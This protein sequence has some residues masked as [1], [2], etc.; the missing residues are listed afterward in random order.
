[1]PKPRPILDSSLL[2]PP[3]SPEQYAYFENAAEHPFQADAAEPSLVNAWWLAE[4][5]L[6]AY[7]HE[8][9]A[10]QIYRLGGLRIAGT[11]SGTHFGGC[12]YVLV[13]EKKII[14][15]F[16][17]TRVV[18]A[19]HLKDAET[20]RKQVRKVLRD[21]STDAK[22]RQVPWAGRSGGMV[23]RGFADSF[24][25]LL[26][27]IQNLVALLR[28][29]NPQLHLWLTGHSLGAALA[30]LAAECLDDVQGIHL[31]GSPQVGDSEFALKFVLRGWRFRHHA[32][33]I[34]WAPSGMLGYQHVKPGAYFDCDGLPGTEPH[35]IGL[36]SDWL[37][38]LPGNAVDVWAS[39]RQGGFSSL[40][41]EAFNDH[42]PIFYAVLTWNA[43]EAQQ[44]DD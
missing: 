13:D 2:L 42:A 28:A 23:H 21:V 41:P 15:A 33:V 22:V 43:Y 3:V 8:A 1:M 26:P 39:L 35:S 6:A 10:A 44:R 30:T 14:L 31:F 4:C 37:K 27:N 18:K 17:G 24:N 19:D 38:G 32:D 29:E 9:M 36:L 20:F 12:C 34:C 5:G 40:A 7:A 25:E 11:V 16:R